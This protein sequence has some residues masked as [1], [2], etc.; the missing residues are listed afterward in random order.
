MI[1]PRAS[2]ILAGLICSTLFLGVTAASALAQARPVAYPNPRPEA[3]IRTERTFSFTDKAA[4]DGG[5]PAG[6][7]F[8]VLCADL[9]Q[10]PVPIDPPLGALPL[11]DPDDFRQEFTKTSDGQETFVWDPQNCTNPITFVPKHAYHW[12]VD[13][14]AP[15]GE[16]YTGADWQFYVPMEEPCDGSQRVGVRVRFVWERDPGAPAG[17]VYERVHI[18]SEFDTMGAT[19]TWASRA[20]VSWPFLKKSYDRQA[21]GWN[22]REYCWLHDAGYTAL[23]PNTRY[24]WRIS[25]HGADGTLL[26]WADGNGNAGPGWRFRTIPEIPLYGYNATYECVIVYWESMYGD[27]ARDP[28]ENDYHF[29]APANALKQIHENEHSPSIST[30]V[31]GTEQIAASYGGVH[32]DGTSQQSW[33]STI[34]GWPTWDNTRTDTNWPRDLQHKYEN[35]VARGLRAFLQDAANGSAFGTYND[36][37]DFPNLQYIVLLG[38]GDRVAPSTYYFNASVTTYPMWIPTD[39][40][41]ST[42]DDTSNVRTTPRYQVSRI[43]LRQKFYRTVD[44]VR[45]GGVQPEVDVE[46]AFVTKIRRYVQLMNTTT[47]KQTAY[48]E[49]FGRAVVVAGS[50]EFDR[51]FPFFNIASQYLLNQRVPV[52]GGQYRDAFS[53]IQVRRYDIF[54]TA[55]EEMSTTNILQHMSNPTNQADVPGFVYWFGRGTYM[56]DQGR[57]DATAEGHRMRL[58]PSLGD[59]VEY[60]DFTETYPGTDPTDGRR[61]LLLTAASYANVFD[62]ALWRG[63]S[64]PPSI[65]EIASLAEGGPIG[66]VG[67]TSPDY[68]IPAGGPVRYTRTWPDGSSLTTSYSGSTDEAEGYLYA[69][70]NQGVI[71]PDE[72]TT[73]TTETTA[74][75]GKMEFLNLFAQ[76]YA[77]TTQPGMGNVFNKALARYV[78]NHLTELNANHG[79]V[80]TTVFGA[81]LLGDCAL[82]MPMRQRAVKDN[83]IPTVTDTNPRPATPVAGYTSPTPQY[84]NHNIPLHVIP[85]TDPYDPNNGVRVALRILTD[86]PYVRV[87]VLTPFLQNVDYERG[88]W[89]DPTGTWWHSSDPEVIATQNAACTYTFYAKAPS[90]YLVLVQAQ[91]PVWQEG[92]HA[93]EWRWLTEKYIYVRAVNEFVRDSTCNILVVDNDQHER[94]YLNGDIC[95]HWEDYYINPDQDGKGYSDGTDPRTLRHTPVLPILNYDLGDLVGVDPQPYRYH[96]WANDVYQKWPTAGL[97]NTYARYADTIRERQRYYGDLTPSVLRSFQDSRGIVLWFDGDYRSSFPQGYLFEYE[98]IPYGVTEL[99]ANYISNGGRFAIFSQMLGWETYGT[100]SLPYLRTFQANYL[101]AVTAYGDTDYTNMDGLQAGTPSEYI[102]DVNIAG[103]DG[104]NNATRTP[105]LDANGVDALPVFF[106]DVTSGPGTTRSTRASAVQ[107]RNAAAGSRTL[108]FAW[109]FEAIDHLGNLQA[110]NSGRENIMRQTIDWLRSV[111]KASNPYPPDQSRGIPLFQPGTTPPVPTALTWNRVPEARA[112]RIYFGTDPLN[113]T[114]P[115]DLVDRDNPTWT[116]AALTGNTRYYWRVDCQNVD[117]WTIG[118]VWSF[119][120]V[121]PA[122]KCTGPNPANGA[123]EVLLDLSDLSPSGAFSWSNTGDVDTFDLY[124]WEEDLTAVPRRDATFVPTRGSAY[125]IGVDIPGDT[126]EFTLPFLLNPNVRYYWRVDASNSLP[127]TAQGDVW[128]FHTI[129][130]PGAPTDPDP[131]DGC[132]SVATNKILG[133]QASV[134]DNRRTDTY[135]VFVWRDDPDAGVVDTPPAVDADVTAFNAALNAAT[136]RSWSGIVTNDKTAALKTFGP[137]ELETGRRYAWQVRPRNAAGRQN[138]VSTWHFNTAATVAAPQAPNTPSP[139]NGASGISRTP[140]LQWQGP[141]AA[142]FDLYFWKAT[143]PVPTTPLAADL[144]DTQYRLTAPTTPL[145]PGEQYNWRVVAKNSKTPPD[146]ATGPPTGAWSFIVGAAQVSGMQPVD[147]STNVPTD[148]TLAWSAA[149]GAASYRLYLWVDGTTMPAPVVVTTTQYATSP[150]GLAANTVYRWRVD[151]VDANGLITQ[152]VEQVFSTGA[153]VALPGKVTLATMTPANGTAN[154]GANVTLQWQATANATSYNVYLGATSPPTT[155]VQQSGATQYAATGLANGNYYWRVD[156]VNSL[157]VTPGDEAYFTVGPPPTQPPAQVTRAMMTPANGT[158]NLGRNVTLQWQAA[159][160]AAIYSVYL[161][162]V[163]PPVTLVQQSGA[164]QYQATGL[165]NDTYYWRVDASNAAGTTTGQVSSFTVG[166]PAPRPPS[167]GGGGGGCFIATS[168]Y[169]ARIAAETATVVNCTGTYLI[170][171]E[172]L[173]KLNHIRALR[174]TVLLRAEAGRNFCAWYYA[175]GPY[176]ATFIRD[177]EP[178]KGLVRTMLLAPLAELS[179]ESLEQGK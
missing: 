44:Q 46:P 106:W 100:G 63:I 166:A 140:T 132:G 22:P 68:T 72:K 162:T 53:G 134:A 30:L 135:E 23:R 123:T 85:R 116:P 97:Q 130:P 92:V 107:N 71:V 10:I 48:Q 158:G 16:T 66:V 76:E 9:G 26:G 51:W 77:K 11:Q 98:T 8:R 24:E 151:S 36:H 37:A 7:R 168:A 145:T 57:T 65:G 150:P 83:L 40:F 124:L 167:G 60:S 147:G 38:D 45:A 152:G 155:L 96:Y 178:V 54:G 1:H 144:T 171:A 55:E 153:S 129:T 126:P 139:A 81:C 82:V 154:L 80:A 94:V 115:G 174:D 28:E 12:R 84:D 141:G 131:P 56:S 149:A 170:P 157:G 18:K 50:I 146:T 120:T 101:G 2:R 125:H 122:I 112:Y 3:R 148:V 128:T 104:A 75:L 114:Q 110:D 25:Y 119:T 156:A 52:G 34:T 4:T 61:P 111:P 87:R 33:P 67:F 86:A 29:Q 177:N 15:G 20:G 89:A 169:E 163:N 5:N 17:T 91:N 90:V 99:L 161:D 79:R 41:Y 102:Q 137:M 179:R 39:F 74:V 118:D 159:T 69:T 138:T 35:Y 78:A 93:E 64:T 105:E 121:A 95:S 113:L 136:G 70:I 43:P 19:D 109:P 47:K 32:R 49:W 13:V 58:T 62:N 173:E 14:I 21:T 27:C 103:G 165:A 59:Y 143:D 108:F 6:T 142:T 73:N 164:T 133:W 31:L 175:L 88:K 117:D 127:S 160:G 176:A 42:Q 172:R